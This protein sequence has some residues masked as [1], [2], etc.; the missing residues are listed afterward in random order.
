MPS[1]K[2]QVKR[3]G[4]Q[5]VSPRNLPLLVRGEFQLD[6][7]SN[8]MRNV[9]LNLEDVGQLTVVT[10]RLQTVATGGVNQLRG[11]TDALPRNAK[12]EVRAVTLRSGICV[13]ALMISSAKPSPKYS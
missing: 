6:G 8:G 11:D 2:V 9:V 12:A 1:L 10:L 4:T 3:L 5:R 7:C 13:S